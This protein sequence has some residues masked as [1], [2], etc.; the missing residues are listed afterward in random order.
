MSLLRGTLLSPAV[1]D[2]HSIWFGRLKPCWS[3]R[4]LLRT[5]TQ[6]A[7]MTLD[8]KK[9]NFAFSFNGDLEQAD[10]KPNFPKTAARGK[11]DPGR[12]R[13]QRFFGGAP[14]LHC[15][16][17][18]GGERTPGAVE[19]E[20]AIVEFFF[21]E[22]DQEGINVRSANLSWR[23]SRLSLMGKLLAEPKALRLDMDIS[24]DRVVWEEFSEL[25]DRG[26][27]GGKA[28]KASQE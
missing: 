16:W 25:I 20:S 13:S 21:L 14:A 22:A 12:H 11:L 18:A 15:P 7:R 23:N 9:D 6:S 8:L 27:N 4:S 1:R 17:T 28:M 3:K 19:G 24:A 2:F 26:S 5:A 10:A